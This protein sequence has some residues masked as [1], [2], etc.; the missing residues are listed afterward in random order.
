MAYTE[1]T[2]EEASDVINK[3]GFKNLISIEKLP[4]GWAN[5]NYILVLDDQTK[6]VLKIWNEQSQDEV[7]YLLN[8]TSYLVD[9]GIPTPK[10]IEF[11]NEELIFMKDGLPWT[12]LPF[13]DGNWL[14]HDYESLF[15]LGVIQA[16]MHTIKP[17]NNLKSDFSMGEK[18]FEK[19]FLIA[20]TNNDWNDFL[21]E[22]KSS[23]S[24]F[25]N[26]DKL[27]RGIIHGDLFP[28]NV[29]GDNNGA[30]SILDFEEVCNG[31]LAFDLVMTFVGF[32][33]DGGE[34]V[35]E[36]WHAILDGYQ[37]IRKLSKDELS[38]LT[39]LHKLATLSIAAWRYWQFKINI[40]GTEH[41]DRYLEM[42]SR[43][44]KELPF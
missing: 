15:S 22:L 1:V 39:D 36:R 13:V 35:S 5:S 2:L 11:D 6:L 23:K 44:G 34:P 24:L 19:L 41:E 27:P 26:L 20:D 7:N 10:P 31:I 16:K 42:T 17:P 32:G 14:G 28:D 4:G 38:S 33:W 30:I 3:A 8:I 37:S 18:L 43:L 12:L 21:I 9:S 29:I 25:L 40:P